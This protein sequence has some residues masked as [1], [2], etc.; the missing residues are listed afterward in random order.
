MLHYL[1]VNV[2]KPA[3]QCC[4]PDRIPSYS[5]E[6]ICLI[7]LLAIGATQHA[8]AAGCEGEGGQGKQ[9]GET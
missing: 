4:K 6:T 5:N 7:A 9:G 2:A 1:P 8:S 3:G